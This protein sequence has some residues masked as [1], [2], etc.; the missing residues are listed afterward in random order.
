LTEYSKNFVIV[1]IGIN[2]KSNPAITAAYETTKMNSYKRGVTRDEVLPILMEKLDFWLARL[3]RGNFASIRT[4][5][6]E[7]AAGLNSEIIYKGHPA[8]LCEINLDGALVLRR[9]S[10]YML[11]FGDEISI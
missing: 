10:E 11:V 2:I 8:T 3:G 5:W 9:G 1:G 7:L 4:K 6:M